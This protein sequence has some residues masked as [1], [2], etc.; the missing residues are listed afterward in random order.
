M[1]FGQLSGLLDG[2]KKEFSQLEEQNKET[3]YTSK[4]G[5]GMVSVSFNGVGELVDLQIDDSLLEDKE[6]MQIYL[7]SALNDGYKNVDENRKNLA[8]KMLGNFTK[9]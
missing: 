7:M 1:D 4:S 2:V 6:A 8:F 5:G 3:I 9:L